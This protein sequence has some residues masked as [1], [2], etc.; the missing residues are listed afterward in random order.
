M[1]RHLASGYSMSAVVSLE[2][3]VD[4]TIELFLQRI[5]E[6]AD[7]GVA[8]DMSKW[9]KWYAFD[10]IGKLTFSTDFGFLQRQEDVGGNLK[11]IEDFVDYGA[12]MGN[13][14]DLH[15]YMLGNPLVKN[16][17]APPGEIIG[18]VC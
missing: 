4:Q 2:P 10:V 12:V 3:L 16:F 17:M 8:M 5:G 15:K 7:A 11:T 1:N 14:F 18:Q 9:F 13:A 6:Q